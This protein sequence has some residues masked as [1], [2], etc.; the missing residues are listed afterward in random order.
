MPLLVVETARYLRLWNLDRGCCLVRSPR[1]DLM[2][3]SSNVSAHRLLKLVST[4]KG[5]NL[6]LILK[7]C[8]LI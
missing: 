5:L 2:T 8:L 6:N 7:V 4:L 1:S 3:V